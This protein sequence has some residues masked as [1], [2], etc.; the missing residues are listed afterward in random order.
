MADPRDLERRAAALERDA[1]HDFFSI[2]IECSDTLQAIAPVRRRLWLMNVVQDLYRNQQGLCA[3]CNE[4]LSAKDMDV[5]HKV[6]F[7]YGG[8]NE[9]HNIQL[10]HSSCNR[11]KQAEVDPHELLRYLEDRYMNL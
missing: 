2:L 6:P 1:Y 5:D 11:S 7:C 3:L 4:P 9:R 10:A 8:G